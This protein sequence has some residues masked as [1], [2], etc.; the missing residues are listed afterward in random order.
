LMRK[1]STG[2]KPSTQLLLCCR[3]ISVR[4]THDDNYGCFAAHAAG[5]MSAMR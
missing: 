5:V 1:G 4:A 2:M 3:K